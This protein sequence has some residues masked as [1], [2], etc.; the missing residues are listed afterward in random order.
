M[1]ASRPIVSFDPMVAPSPEII[2]GSSY[3]TIIF[4]TIYIQN[5]S[6]LALCLITKVQQA[7]TNA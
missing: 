2:D 7:Y 6:N 4:N 5:P 3:C 1:V